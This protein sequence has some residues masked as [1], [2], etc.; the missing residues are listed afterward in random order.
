[1]RIVIENESEL[2]VVEKILSNI[3]PEKTTTIEIVNEIEASCEI[4]LQ[5]GINLGIPEGSFVTVSLLGI[6]SE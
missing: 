1:M 3:L 5:E 6:V 2:E 4:Q